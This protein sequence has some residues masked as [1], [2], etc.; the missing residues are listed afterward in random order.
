M[1]GNGLVVSKMG[2]L[3]IVKHRMGE[4]GMLS[5][6]LRLRLHKMRV[7]RITRTRLMEVLRGGRWVHWN[8]TPSLDR[9]ALS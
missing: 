6:M 7:M 8:N 3:R 1:R 2:V 5:K 9:R 4:N